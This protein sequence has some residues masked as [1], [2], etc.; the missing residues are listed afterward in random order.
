[1]QL[2][3]DQEATITATTQD[4]EVVVGGYRIYLPLVLRGG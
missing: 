3:D 4:G 1:V 2:V